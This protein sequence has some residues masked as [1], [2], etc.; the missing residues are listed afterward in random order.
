MKNLSIIFL[1][2]GILAHL[3]GAAVNFIHFSPSYDLLDDEIL[4][5]NCFMMCDVA[6]K[7]CLSFFFYIYHST[8]DKN[9]L[10]DLLLLATVGFI[11]NDIL[12][13]FFFDPYHWQMNE[14]ILLITII[15]TGLYRVC[16]T[17]MTFL[18]K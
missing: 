18:M 2:L 5:T 13:E 1:V 17:T 7:F 9:E 4:S 10:L 11:V 16:K 14:T 6:F 3:G 15:I 12:D 8:K